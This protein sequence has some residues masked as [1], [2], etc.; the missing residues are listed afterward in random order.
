MDTPESPELAIE[1]EKIQIERERLALERERLETERANYRQT[2]ALSNRAAGRLTIP[3]STLVLS[4]VTALLVGGIAALW[5]SSA[6]SADSDEIAATI[7]H[8]LDADYD[9]DGTNGVPSSVRSPFIRALNRR[10][11]TG[12][13]LLILD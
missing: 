9:D 12:G 6:R 5:I 4:L 1:R 7:A 10:G 11:R 8:A 13:Y 3:I 2:V